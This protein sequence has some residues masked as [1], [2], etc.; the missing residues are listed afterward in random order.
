MA[1]VVIPTL[2]APT[3][4]RM[5]VSIHIQTEVIAPEI[6][7]KRANGWL[8]DNVGNL[9]RAETPELILDKSLIWRADVVLTSP[10]HGVLGYVGRL[11]IDALTGEVL[12]DTETGETLI[13]HAQNL[14]H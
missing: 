8:L 3:T 7:R 10:A 14:T 6:A 5:Q 11:E 12:A 1:A 9:L 13:A 4:S 2:S